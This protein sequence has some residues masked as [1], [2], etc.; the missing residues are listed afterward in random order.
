MAEQFMHIGCP[1]LGGPGKEPWSWQS[2]NYWDFAGTTLALRAQSF[3][4]E[5][6]LMPFGAYALTGDIKEIVV[7]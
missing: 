1:V 3:G 2:L 4:P 6:I 7:R 5:R